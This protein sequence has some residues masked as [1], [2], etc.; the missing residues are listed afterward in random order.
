MGL[1]K[2]LFLLIILFIVSYSLGSYNKT[3]PLIIKEKP[4]KLRIIVTK[5]LINTRP[6]PYELGLDVLKEYAMKYGYSFHVLRDRHS[7]MENRAPAW[8]KL[9]LYEDLCSTNLYDWVFIQDG[10]AII[11]NN[12]V[13]LESLIEEGGMDKDLIVIADTLVLNSGVMFCKCS[14]W[15]K[16][17]FKLA[18]KVWPLEPS[19]MQENGAIAATMVGCNDKSTFKERNA[20]YY[21]ADL[22]WRDRE[23]MKRNKNADRSALATLVTPDVFAHV[24]WVVKTHMNSYYDDYEIGH[25][26]LHAAAKGG[27]KESFLMQHYNNAKKMKLI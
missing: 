14:E 8:A 17:F 18:W 24:G 23:F 1:K 21:K 7:K 13:R 10:D 15:T 6:G 11:L 16:Q 3:C 19:Y 20:C 9:L 2:I 4:T 25:F 22:G 27:E 5:V 12:T 26:I